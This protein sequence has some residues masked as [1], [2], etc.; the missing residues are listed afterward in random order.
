MLTNKWSTKQRILIVDDSVTSAKLIAD[1]V[2]KLGDIFIATSGKAAIEIAK[3]CLPDLVL[4][5]I[6]MP[7]MNGYEVFEQL[8][9]DITTKHCEVIFITA[10][11]DE[12][13]EVKVFDMG[14]M[15]FI[16]KPINTAV[17]QSR[18][19]THITLIRK[20][21]QLSQTKRELA[22]LLST[23]PAFI[24]YWNNDLV[25]EFCNDNEGKWFNLPAQEIQDK[26]IN[27]LFRE[28]ELDELMPLIQDTL[29]RNNRFCEMTFLREGKGITYAQVSL[30]YKQTEEGSDG[31]LMVLSD[32]TERKLAENQLFEEKEKLSITLNAIGDGVIATDTHGNISFINPIAEALTGWPMSQAIGKPIETVMRVE[33][34]G[35]EGALV[36]PIRLALSRREAVG[37]VM[38][39]LLVKKDGKKIEIEDSASPIFNRVGEVIGAIIIFHDVSEARAMAMK[40]THIAQHDALTN[41]PNRV[42]LRD[43]TE[44]AI[45]VAKRDRHFCAL[46]LIDIDNFK[47]INDTQ[48]HMVG[49]QLLQLIAHYLTGFLRDSDTLSRQGGDEFLILLSE[50]DDPEN[51]ADFC[52]RIRGSFERQWHIDS[53]V[54]NIT[55][56][57][58]VSIY[59]ND[60]EDPDTLYRH[61][62]AAMY[63]AKRLG[64]NAFHFFSDEIER[65]I[66]VRYN[67]ENQLREGIENDAFEVFYQPKVD[68]SSKTIIGAEALVRWRK[69]DGTLEYPDTFIQMAEETGLIIPMGNIVLRKAC[70]QAIEWEQSGFPITVAVNIS[71]IQFNDSLVS[72]VKDLIDETGISPEN[73]ELEIT[74][75]V[76]LKGESVYQTI[77]ELK[78]LGVRLAMDDFGTGYSSLS[79]VKRLPLDVLKIDQSFVRNMI[80]S[81]VDRSIVK[82]IVQ[83]AKDLGFDLVAEGVET[84][85]HVR[86]LLSLGCTH[87]QG[88]HYSKPVP[89]L[90]FKQLLKNGLGV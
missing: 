18:V 64:R 73:L 50:I 46:I 80:N 4:L 88:Y 48:G 49:D 59:P 71:A 26:S 70:Q 66:Q 56:S 12:A 3:S 54:F 78:G 33:E 22:E 69:P 75:T 37:L 36:N 84:I 9:N 74:E 57:M 65:Q 53:L 21:Q 77:K 45:K 29:K 42:L 34:M 41:L 14:G 5:D 68:G 20:T 25:S 55:V 13:A 60:G 81:D 2:S 72:T 7:E 10:Q 61:A 51:I 43:R 17:L 62:D 28:D 39:C 35:A 32:I 6:N 76:L 89:Q 63:T 85:E 40:M 87:F 27:L 31:V 16:T 86:T 90:E 47:Q 24:S 82:A 58:G 67:I 8:K 44:Q 11:N 30:I 83:L 15:D 79:Y 38:D 1:T 19:K 23:L 52:E